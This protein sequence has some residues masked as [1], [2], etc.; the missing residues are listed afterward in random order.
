MED[1]ALVLYI[2][3]IVGNS[4][5]KFK[6]MQHW[7]SKYGIMMVL[8]LLLISCINISLVMWTEHNWHQQCSV[9]TFCPVIVNLP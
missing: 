7:C 9:C 4:C 6:V 1:N 3:I 5:Y 8:L 2:C